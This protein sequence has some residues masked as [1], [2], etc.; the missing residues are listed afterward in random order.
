MER[1]SS[2]PNSTSESTTSKEA[3]VTEKDAL[4]STDQRLNKLSSLL[5]NVGPDNQLPANNSIQPEQETSSHPPLDAQSQQALNPPIEES[6]A[7]DQ[8]IKNRLGI[9]SSLFFAIDAKHPLTAAHSLRVALTCT[10]WGEFMKHDSLFITNLEIAALLHDVGKIGLPDKILNKPAEL[11]F[12]EIEEIEKH[13]QKGLYILASCSTPFEVLET[14]KY[15]AAWYNGTRAGYDKQEESLPLG[16]RILAIADAFDSMTTDQVYRQAFSRER[17]LSE[18]YCNANTQFDI[19]LVESFH[20]FLN[21]HPNYFKS[22]FKSWIADLNK[23]E[24]THIFWKLETALLNRATPEKDDFHHQFIDHSQDAVFFLNTSLQI[25]YWNR[26][27]EDLTGLSSESI[28]QKEWSP[29]IFE[30][31]N[32]L[33]QKVSHEECPIAEV[34]RDRR[35][36]IKRFYICNRQGKHIAVSTQITP[37]F[38]SNNQ[39]LGAAVSMHDVSG[40]VV[41]EQRVETL[42]T[43]ATRDPLT[44]VSNRSEFDNH[45]AQFVEAYHRENKVSSL[46]MCDIDYFK[47]IN[48]TYGHQAGDE[49]L[50]DFAKILQTSWRPGDLIARYGGE[51]FAIL[52]N[53]LDNNTA[54][55]RAEKLRQELAEIP[56]PALKGQQL[57][58]SFGVTEL[59]SGDTPESFLGRADRALMQAKE[60]GRNM[61]IQLGS[62]QQNTDNKAK[63]KTS[64][65]TW[66][67]SDSADLILKRTLETEVPLEVALEKLKGF[68]IDLKANII[69]LNESTLSLEISRKSQNKTTNTIRHT[70]FAVDIKFHQQQSKN[71]KGQD[72]THTIFDLSIRPKRNRDRRQKAVLEEAKLLLNSF[73]SYMIAY[74][75]AAYNISTSKD[76]EPSGKFYQAIKY[77][78]GPIFG[79]R[80]QKKPKKGKR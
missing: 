39:L 68:V 3:R 73:K 27:A 44:S 32:S 15:S 9:A 43:K 46:I 57:T 12:D 18:L 54:T 76:L 31:Q 79:K 74:E 6:S 49:A 7:A 69:A 34:L 64:W 77:W 67:T 35:T 80:A 25:T 2:Q 29:A 51:E 71:H 36:L 52:C 66:L 59:Q 11:S 78:I 63:E 47:K 26:A 48:D 19:R 28:L 62:G 30:L 53:D 1:P 75:R 21:R 8:L 10:A 5:D 42:H 41:L 56:Q 14:I 17:A 33:G 4:Q 61:V 23:T 45:L 20:Q 40:R 16:A 72:F 37:V 13:R 22:S 70:P 50:I 55:E 60:S 58:A 65:F 38:S 24:A